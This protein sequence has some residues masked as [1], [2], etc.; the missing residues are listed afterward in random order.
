LKLLNSDN[1]LLYSFVISLLSIAGIPPFIGFWSKTLLVLYVA[2]L[3]I[4]ET[5]C[6]FV[7]FLIS[8]IFYFEFLINLFIEFDDESFYN[9]NITST[10]FNILFFSI[11]FLFF[12]LVFFDDFLCILAIL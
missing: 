11:F 3:S 4:L 12:G 6:I 7:L 5:S 2:E 8:I 1:I 10:H 9:I